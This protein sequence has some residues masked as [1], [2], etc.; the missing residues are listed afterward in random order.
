VVERPAAAE[1]P[2]TGPKGIANDLVHLMGEKRK[3]SS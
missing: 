2:P 1:R 3:N